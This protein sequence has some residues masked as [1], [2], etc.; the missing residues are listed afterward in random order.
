MKINRITRIFDINYP[1]GVVRDDWCQA[2][3]VSRA[4]GL[5][6]LEVTAENLVG[7]DAD[8][9][10][11]QQA[12]GKPLGVSLPLGLPW[13][14]NAV[15]A[16]LRLPVKVVMT[17]GGKPTLHTKRLHD[18]GIMVMHVVGSLS[19]IRDCEEAGVDVIVVDETSTD[20]MTERKNLH[21]VMMTPAARRETSLPLVAC[22]GFPTGSAMLSAMVVGA[23]GV[24]ADLTTENVD[25]EYSE[26]LMTAAVRRFVREFRDACVS[27]SFFVNLADD[28]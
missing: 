22:G 7:L 28:I 3:A 1:I 19:E 14:D 13:S 10:V 25:K 20:G 17:R 27:A 21:T 23:E 4:G 8:A 6:L 26:L 11:F 9:G 12:E 24:I 18:A 16:M 2:L 15:D 5:G